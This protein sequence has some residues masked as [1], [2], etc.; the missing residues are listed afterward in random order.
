MNILVFEI[1][2]KKKIEL[3]SPPWKYRILRFHRPAINV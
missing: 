3:G 1:D 2:D